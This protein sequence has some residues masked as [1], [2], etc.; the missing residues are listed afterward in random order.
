MRVL[1][2]VTTPRPFFDSQVETLERRGVECTT[3]SVPR[4][5][6]GRGLRDY[7]RFYPDVLAELAL[8]HDVIHANYGLTAPF[9]LAQP[10]LP[11]VVTFWGTDLMGDPWLGRLSRTAASLADAVVLPSETLSSHLSRTHTLVPFGVDTDRFRP[12]PRDEARRRIGWPTDERI[13]L[14][15]YD[16]AR[17][18]KDFPR[19]ER[20]VSALEADAS[21]KPISGVPYEEMPSYVNASDALL[22]T[23][24]RESGPMVVKE[25]AA[26]N[27]PVVST[28]VGFVGEVLDG[29]SN[30]TVADADAQLTAA[31]D[32][33][34]ASGA[35]ADGRDRI[36]CLGL[37][38]MG[39][40]LLGVYEGVL[41]G[42]GRG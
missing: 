15:P 41:D 27:V 19:A 5:A 23:S 39:D 9:A 14:F 37:A 28:D 34:L 7:L 32:R 24:K 25:A 22:V 26:C 20:V 21:L 35:R 6:G 1:N 8:S 11:V 30:S 4:P 13:V 10:K 29:V 12:M 16:P 18:V 3:L 31:L 42:G 40:R 33:V 2:L 17:A 36:D 38:E